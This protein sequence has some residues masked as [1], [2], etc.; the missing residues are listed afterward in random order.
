MGNVYFLSL[1]EKHWFVFF[2][3][4]WVELIGHL[5]ECHLKLVEVLREKCVLNTNKKAAAAKVNA[6]GQA[7]NKVNTVAKKMDG[8]IMQLSS[9]VDFLTP[10]L[11]Y[12]K[13]FVV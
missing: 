11:W 5:Q 10:L 6:P 7:V 12:K 9:V 2:S 4:Q 8:S 3:F 13:L 1:F